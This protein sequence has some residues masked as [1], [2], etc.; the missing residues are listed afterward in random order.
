M[1]IL[2]DDTPT[3]QVRRRSRE[4]SARGKGK[5]DEKRSAE[6]HNYNHNYNHNPPTNHIHTY[7][8][9]DTY[10]YKHVL[11]HEQASPRA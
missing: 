1:K 9:Y 11:C 10:I 3:K 2:N 4:A 8:T 6:T 7:F 5:S